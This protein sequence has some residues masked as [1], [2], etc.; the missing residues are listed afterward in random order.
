[1]KLLEVSISRRHA[2]IHTEQCTSG[3]VSCSTHTKTTYVSYLLQL[4]KQSDANDGA[5]T[6]VC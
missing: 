6:A 5:N 4:Y 2:L 3:H 1:M